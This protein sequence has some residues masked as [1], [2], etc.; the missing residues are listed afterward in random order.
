MGTMNKSKILDTLRH[1]KIFRVNKDIRR[2]GRLRKKLNAMASKAN[3]PIRY[4]GIEGNNLVF[5][6][7]EDELTL[8]IFKHSRKYVTDK[9]GETDE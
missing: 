9:Y 5:T 7:R 4:E 8:E 6:Y 2:F 3:S 1:Y